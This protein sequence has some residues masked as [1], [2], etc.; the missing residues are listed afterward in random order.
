MVNT[1]NFEWIRIRAASEVH[2][3][4]NQRSHASHLDQVRI[5]CVVSIINYR[6]LETSSLPRWGKR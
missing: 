5:S 6:T 4:R 3:G 1:R 2:A